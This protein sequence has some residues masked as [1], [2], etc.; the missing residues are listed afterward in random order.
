MQP[1]P[2]TASSARSGGFSP[3]SPDLVMAINLAYVLVVR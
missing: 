2:G 1:I 3:D